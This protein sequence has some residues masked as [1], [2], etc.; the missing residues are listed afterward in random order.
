MPLNVRKLVMVTLVVP[1]QSVSQY[2]KLTNLNYR[3]GNDAKNDAIKLNLIKQVEF[4]S[5]RRG[6]KTVLIAPT[7][8]AFEMFGLPPLYENPGYLHC[9]L[10]E[11]VRQA[12]T[13]KGFRA[14]LEKAV[15]KKR[16]DVW[17]EK[18]SQKLAVEIA[19]T[20]KHEVV[21]VRKDIFKAGAKKVVIIGKD[22]K[23]VS[24][25]EKKLQAAFDKDILAKV[26][27]C[28]L[29]DFIGKHN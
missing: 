16:I 14:S 24:S 8:P 25:V 29:A 22:K 3:G 5:G 10:A 21:N 26:T 13:A 27:V 11:Q 9:Y 19:T 12:M 23:V 20:D 1:F 2:Y 28:T 17:L 4:H 15:G 6:G 7:K 18:D